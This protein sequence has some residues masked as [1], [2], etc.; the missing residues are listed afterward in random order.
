MYTRTQTRDTRAYGYAYLSGILRMGE[1]RTYANISRQVGVSEQ[2]LQHYLSNSPWRSAPLLRQVRYD[3]GFH[4]HFATGSMLLLD[5]SANERSGAESAGSGRQYNGRLG[6]VDCCQVGVFLSLT[7][8]GY[9]SWVDGELFLPEAWFAPAAAELRQQLGIPP[10]RT[11]QTKCQLGWQMIQ[12]AQAEGIPF[13]AIDCDGFYGRDAHFRWQLDEAG[14]EY[15]ADVPA[16][17]QVYLASPL[18]GIPGQRQGRPATQLRILSP[19]HYRV[20][21]LRTHP[22]LLWHTLTL[23][24]TERGFL[25]AD[26]ARVRVWLVDDAF[27]ITEQWLLLRRDGNTHTY[28]LSN[29]PVTATLHT[30]ASRKAQRYFIERANQDAKSELGWDELQAVKFTAWEHQ[31]AFTIL[32]QWFLTHTRLDWAQRFDRNPALLHC[33]A[34]DCLPPLSVANL[35][36]LLLAVLPLPQFSPRQAAAFVIR[37]LVNRTRSR[38]SR[39][40]HPGET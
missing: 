32:A 36:A 24:T 14:L 40:L 16:N 19:R 12:R 38:K 15:Y 18:I 1:K 26:F 28:T 27:H 3:I 9:S 30:M 31:L 2:N 13:D 11:F 21:Q 39:L 35:R 7:K 20:D 25:T 17:T 5:E 37:H 33:F 10:E 34:V 8:A 4:P 22:A 23:R 6:K 29:A